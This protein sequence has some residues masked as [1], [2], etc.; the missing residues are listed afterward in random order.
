[1]TRYASLS[2]VL[3]LVSAFALLACNSPSPQFMDGSQQTVETG[4]MTFGVWRVG[5][6]VEVIRTSMHAVPRLSEVRRNAVAAVLIATGCPVK[7]GTVTGDQAIT[8][9]KLDCPG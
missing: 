6:E 2:L 7:D 5:D 8:L 3:S 4:G 9:A 1:M